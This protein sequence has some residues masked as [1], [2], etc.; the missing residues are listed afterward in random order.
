MDG[1]Y[2]KLNMYL[3]TGN[4]EQDDL[5]ENL[6]EFLSMI[7]LDSLNEQQNEKINEI[8]N[9]MQEDEF[10]NERTQRVVRSG[11]KTR[12]VVCKKGYK[13]QDGKC[14]KMTSKERKTRSKAAK[15]SSRTKTNKSSTE[16]KRQKSL[17]K[18]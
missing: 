14:V 16:R 11:K 9:L 3:N 12:K 6:I 17:R 10:L 18:R 8:I 2:S 4:D 7:D 13:A 1:L 15:R 5:T